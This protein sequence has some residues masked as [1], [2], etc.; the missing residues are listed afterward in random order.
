MPLLCALLLASLPAISSAC[1][2][3]P[4]T[5][6]NSNGTLCLP[7]L[8]PTSSNANASQGQGQ[9]QGQGQ[10]QSQSSY[11]AASAA[12]TSAASANAKGGNAANVGD[13]QST[14]YSSSYSA[15]RQAVDGYS[16]GTNT[17]AACALDQHAGI[18]AVIGGISFGRSR[19]D[20]DCARL[21]LA[22]EMWARGN[23]H[24]AE[25]IF[26]SIGEV[27][28]ALGEDCMAYVH[29]LHSTPPVAIVPP[30]D[31]VTH[32]ELRQ[33]ETRLVEHMASK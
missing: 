7:D 30:A 15:P 27:K 29:T 19:R 16:S 21:V 6:Q 33:V 18:G 32:A 9:T 3:G 12:S 25:A 26:C 8:R 1:E 28:S 20:H 2:C 5:H 23:D 14:S 10:S 13:S 11:S 17:T 4:G 24:A 22:N 31:T